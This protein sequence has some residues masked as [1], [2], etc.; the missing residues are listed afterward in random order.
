[1]RRLVFGSILVWAGLLLLPAALRAQGTST[2]AIAGVVKDASGA[3]LPGV[4]VEASSPAL[5]EK[6]RTTVTDDERRV[7]DHRAASRHLHRHVHA[8]GLQHV[9]ARRPGAGAEFH[10][11]DQRRA[12]GRRH[13]GNRDRLGQHAARRHAERVA[14]ADVLERAA[15]RRADGEEHAGH[16]RAD[17]VGRRAAERA[18][19]RRQ[20]GRALRPPVGARQ[21]DLR[22]AAAAGRHALQRA[23]PGH[24]AA[25]GAR[26]LVRAVARRHGTR[27]LH[28]P[29]G[30][31]GDAHRYR[32]A[33]LGAVPSMAARR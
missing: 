19:R 32:V 14:A 17:A 18:G 1:M 22:L 11:D 25:G 31:A 8:A 28:Q 30:R 20:Q 13:S 10:R 12:R 4:T 9:Q 2:G 16:R 5:I 29:A 21:Q 24:R 15:R 6:I 7:Q 23:D 3:V 33:R 27:L 26:D